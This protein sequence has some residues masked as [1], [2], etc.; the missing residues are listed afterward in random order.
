M[1]EIIN[2]QFGE[3]DRN[4]DGMPLRY[5]GLVNN[6]AGFGFVNLDCSL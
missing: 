2:K 1:K 6:K 5:I 3:E 4:E